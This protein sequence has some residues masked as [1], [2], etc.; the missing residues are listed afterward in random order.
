[1]WLLQEIN[2]IEYRDIQRRKICLATLI[3]IAQIEEES[4]EPSARQIVR[5]HEV[6]VR[7]VVLSGSV[8][9]LKYARVRCER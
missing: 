2:D 3:N 1:M 7:L 4:H 9:H 6:M 8:L 5:I